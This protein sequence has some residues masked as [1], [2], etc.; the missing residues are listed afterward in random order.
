[1]PYE[2]GKYFNKI[3]CFC[4]EEQQ[5]NPNEQV[6]LPVF[7]FVD[8][9][10]NRDPFLFDCNEIVLSY[11]FFETKEGFKLPQP[12]SRPPISQPIQPATV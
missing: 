2:A 4:F 6:D 7:F 12:P 3:Q 10:F 1:L 8:P 5:L 9:E 11:N